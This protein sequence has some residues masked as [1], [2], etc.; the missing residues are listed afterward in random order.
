MRSIL[1][2][3]EPDPPRPVLV[4]APLAGDAP[5]IARELEACGLTACVCRDATDLARRLE[6]NG[7]EGTLFVVA[8]QEGAGQEAGE[9]LRRAFDCEPPWA[10]LPAVFLVS[11]ARRPPPACRMLDRPEYA[12]PPLVLER[13]AKRVVL[14]RIFE[15][16]AA[17]RRRQFETH[18]LLDRLKQSEDRRAFLL[19][20]LRHRTRNS[21]TVLHGIFSLSARR[22]GSVEALREAF[23][24]RLISLANAYAPLS[25]DRGGTRSL[26]SLIRDQV[27]PYCTEPKQLRTTG[28]SVR[29][30][31][32]LV[33]DLALVVHELA[34]NAAKYG[35]LSTPDGVVDVCW[36]RLPEQDLEFVWRERGGPPVEPPRRRGL[37]TSLLHRFPSADARFE[38]SGLVWR[39][40]IPRDG[41]LQEDSAESAPRET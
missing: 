28:P 7:P 23:G 2:S 35:A 24:T 38:R 40:V 19:S 37:G 5:A 39:V 31:E 32:R 15:T 16:Q 41:L 25:E 1:V 27:A 30:R 17:A 21:L 20:E 11:N 10:R 33:F 22:A 29:L 14:R 36:Q 4:L 12:P 8:T 18:D 6:T 13:P 9:A 3:T 26:D 34:T